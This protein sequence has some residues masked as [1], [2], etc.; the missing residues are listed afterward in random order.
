M[1]DAAMNNKG[2]MRVT[3]SKRV[4][5]LHPELKLLCYTRPA[6]AGK[7]PAGDR[8]QPSPASP[9]RRA[10]L[11]T[12]RAGLVIALAVAA[13]AIFVWIIVLTAARTVVYDRLN[14]TLAL[15]TIWAEMGIAL[16]AWLL[17]H[18]VDY[19]HKG[20]AAPRRRDHRFRFWLGAHGA[21]SLWH[22]H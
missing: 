1:L 8:P 9:K 14:Q 7:N 5:S 2:A 4:Q 20:P 19:M 11:W 6:D 21:N 17:L 15:W 13:I 16:P 3:P 22:R 10:L 12:D 18:A